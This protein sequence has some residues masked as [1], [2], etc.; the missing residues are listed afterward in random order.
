MAT[1]RSSL[2]FSTL[3]MLGKTG[4]AE[5]HFKCTRTLP[6]AQGV[7]SWP[8]HKMSQRHSGWRNVFKAPPCCH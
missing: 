1:L 4:S 8:P 2:L 6:W 5:L 7:H 3:R